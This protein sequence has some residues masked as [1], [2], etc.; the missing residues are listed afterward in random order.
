MKS[1][2]AEL[3]RLTAFLT[4]LTRHRVWPFGRVITSFA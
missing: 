2:L 3:S 1:F 4:E